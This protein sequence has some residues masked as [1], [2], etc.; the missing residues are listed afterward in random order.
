MRAVFR[1]GAALAV[2]GFGLLVGC[3]KSEPVAKVTEPLPTLPFEPPS[4]PKATG[5]LPPPSS[6]VL[7]P[8]PTEPMPPLPAIAPGLPGTPVGQPTGPFVPP[9]SPLAGGG[10]LLPSAKPIEAKPLE[11]MPEPKNEPKLQPPVTPTEPTKTPG[12]PSKTP[13][14]KPGKEEKIEYPKSVGGKTVDEW[15]AEMKID[16][17]NY[18]PLQPD[19]AAREAAVKNLVFFG[20]DVREKLVKP[21]INTISWDPDPGVQVAA[22]TIIS[23]IGFDL[24][25]QTKPVVDVLAKKLG[26]SETHS[27]VK[28]YCVRSLTSFGSDAKSAMNVLRAPAQTRNSSWETRR[29]VAIALGIV[30]MPEPPKKPGDPFN[31]PDEAA[32]NALTEVMISDPSIAVRIEAV[33]SLL[34]MGP[35]VP[36]NPAEYAKAVK[37]FLDRIKPRID[38]ENKNKKGDK[39]VYVWLLLLEIM[40]NGDLT[41]ENVKKIADVIKAPDDPF[42]RLAALQALGALGPKA[43]KA[44]PQ[45]MDALNYPEQLLQLTAMMALARIGPSARPA[46]EKLEEIKKKVPVKNLNDPPGTVP[47]DSL[48]KSAADAI[49]YITGKKKWDD[50]QEPKKDDKKDEKVK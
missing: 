39:G 24:R 22:I 13:E 23:N 30:G 29:E 12:E 17:N 34:S 50:L 47:D 32:M 4:E 44:L 7:L 25:K 48:Q 28:M 11:P 26:N 43:A 36:K 41:D 2:A 15:I 35:P 21:L 45:I 46:L 33:K 31:S 8:R 1:L 3:G 37:V 38:F 42:H 19:G 40:Y 18:Q 27:T 10:D 6:A 20:P 16:P 5:P 14:T 49:E 9:N